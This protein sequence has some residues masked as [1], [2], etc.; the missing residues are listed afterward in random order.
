MRR[1]EAGTTTRRLGKKIAKFL[2]K[3]AKKVAKIK[4]V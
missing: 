4:N 2:G 3:V 1:F